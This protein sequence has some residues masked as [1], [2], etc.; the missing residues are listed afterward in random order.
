V[1]VDLRK[2]KSTALPPVDGLHLYPIDIGDGLEI[3]VTRFND[4]FMEL[5]GHEHFLFILND[6][7]FERMDQLHS[8]EFDFCRKFIKILNSYSL[9]YL[10]ILEGGEDAYFDFLRQNR[11]KSE[12]LN[13]KLVPVSEFVEDSN[14]DH[15]RHSFSNDGYLLLSEII[16]LQRLYD[17]RKLH[18]FEGSD[19][20][21][22]QILFVL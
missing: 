13:S 18:F 19:S 1:G 9:N 5:K 14:E 21:E 3:A 17:S 10:A 15:Q 4:S 8:E 2:D 12:I 20:S 16:E 7:S 22:G 11:M 6:F